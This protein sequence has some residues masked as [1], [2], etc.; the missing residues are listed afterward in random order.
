[1]TTGFWP[2]EFVK[3][4]VEELREALPEGRAVVACYGGVDSTVCAVLAHRAFG[5]RAHPVFQD[6]GFMWAGGPRPCQMP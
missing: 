4:A 5:E 6:T 3:K 1:M 2:G